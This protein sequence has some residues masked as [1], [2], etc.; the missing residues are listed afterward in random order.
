MNRDD[1]KTTPQEGEAIKLDDDGIP[2]LDEVVAVWDEAP[3]KTAPNIQAL[4]DTIRQRLEHELHDNLPELAE[5]TARKATQKIIQDMEP[6]I[7]E[8]LTLL[9]EQQTA[10]IIEQILDEELGKLQ[11]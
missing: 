1:H 8:Q 11:E 5:K 3:S 2:I 4:V 7:R 9:L 10:Q 6:L